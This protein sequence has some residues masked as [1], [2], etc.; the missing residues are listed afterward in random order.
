MSY[1]DWLE[2]SALPRRV[3][4]LL[5]LTVECEVAA[6]AQSFSALYALLELEVFLDLQPAHHVRG[7]N[8]RLIEALAASIKG[9]ITLSARVSRIVRE[10]KDGKIR[11]RVSYLKEH[12]VETVEAE[13]VV[14]AVPFV[15]IHQIQIEPPLSEQHWNAL[16]T[17]GFGQYTVVHLLIDKRARSLWMVG[18]AS[19]LP[20]L[21]DG[22]LGVIYGVKEESPQSQPLE[23]FSLLVYGS[24]ARGFHMNPYGE[25]VAEV[26]AELDKLWPGF[27]PHVRGS[28]VYTYH[29]TAIAV[30]PPSR[31]PLD[32]GS[33]LMRKPSLGLYFAGDWT[34]GGHSHDAARSGIEAAEK[35]ARELSQP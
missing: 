32:E 5:R 7:G 18:D 12:R 11:V 21:T 13:R 17:L 20:I 25:R 30:W 31:S 35:I 23:V 4:E 3:S 24:P 16:R 29:P 14:L 22:I 19:P 10:E 33:E 8:S 27:A 1:A 28:E 6:E 2:A 26:V 34:H 15:R 9:P